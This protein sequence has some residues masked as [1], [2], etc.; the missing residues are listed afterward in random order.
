MT[1]QT[2]QSFQPIFTAAQAALGAD[3][4][5]ASA[6][7]TAETRQLYP[8]HPAGPGVGIGQRP[9]GPPGVLRR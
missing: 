3:P 5:R 4:A 8:G 2:R 1:G 7:F 6:I 9:L